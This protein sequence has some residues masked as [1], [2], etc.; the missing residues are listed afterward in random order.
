MPRKPRDT[1]FFCETLIVAS[2]KEKEMNAIEE[3]IKSKKGTFTSDDLEKKVL[4]NISIK[5]AINAWEQTPQLKDPETRR[6]YRRALYRIFFENDSILNKT[7]CRNIITEDTAITCLHDCRGIYDAID[8]WNG[9]EAI[10][11]ICTTAY[12]RFCD[13]LRAKTYGII[14]PAIG[15]RD[16]PSFDKTESICDKV[17]WEKFL[18]TVEMP[19]QL[20]CKLIFLTA[21]EWRYRLRISAKQDKNILSLTTDQIDFQQGTISFREEQSY[22]I[23]GTGLALSLPKDHLDNLK[24]YINGRTGIVFISQE[25]TKLFPVQVERALEKAS[26][27]AGYKFTITPVMLAWAGVMKHKPLIIN[28]N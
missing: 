1:I 8:E 12:A 6:K 25:G 26:R 10:K 23:I 3:Y 15:P 24:A 27:S 14:D 13:Y 16:W 28:S 22:H 21:K 7:K 5:N 2:G 17:D 4:R 20:I 18:N 19:Y 9:S 11:K